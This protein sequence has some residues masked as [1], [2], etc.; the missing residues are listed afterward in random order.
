MSNQKWRDMV[1]IMLWLNF[2]LNAFIFG[3]LITR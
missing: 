2:V 3:V 1:M